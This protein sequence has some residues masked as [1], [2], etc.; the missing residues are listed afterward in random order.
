MANTFKNA[1]AVIDVT[2]G[3]VVYTSPAGAT[4]VIHSLSISNVQVNDQTVTVEVVDQSASSTTRIMSNIA[5]PAGSSI[6]F[7]KPINLEPADF[8]R[9]IGSN[10]A[11]LEAFLSVLQIS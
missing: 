3:T 4:S 11:T 6:Y 5:V 9:I 8:I 2:P 10:A 7:P 1:S